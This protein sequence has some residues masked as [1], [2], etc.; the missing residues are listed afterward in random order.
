MACNEKSVL[1]I[2]WKEAQLRLFAAQGMGD[3]GLAR[4]CQKRIRSIKKALESLKIKERTYWDETAGNLHSL[5]R[6]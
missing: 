4:A 1:L 5:A 2:E 6:W 3:Y